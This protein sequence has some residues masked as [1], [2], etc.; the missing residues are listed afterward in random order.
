MSYFKNICLIKSPQKVDVPYSLIVSDLTEL[1]YLAAMVKNDVDSITFPVNINE[2]NYFH[3]FEKYL[4]H[5]KADMVGISTMTGAYKNALEFARIAKKHNV[6]VVMGGYHPSALPDDVLKSPY[7]DAVI[8]GEGEL[9]FKE[10]VNNG[11]SEDIRGLSFKDNGNISH[12]TDR[13][14][15]TNLDEV[16]HPMRE[17]RPK[18]FGNRGDNYSIDTVYTSR[19]CRIK[20]SFCSNDMV[21]KN[22]RYRSPENV[23]E[24]LKMI[25]STKKRKILK[26]WDANL[27]TSV[28]RIERIVDLMFENNLTNF[29][30]W[31]ESRSTDILKAEPIMQKLH[32]IGLRNM[33]LG[34]ESPNLETLK[35]VGKGTTPQTCERAIELMRN[36]RIK[37]QGYFIIGHLNETIEDIRRYPEYAKMAGVKQ[38]IFMVMTPYPG[39]RIYKDYKK[40]NAITSYNWNMY[41]NF[42]TVV[43]PNNID[44]KT[45]KKAA[46]YCWGKFY[47]VNPYSKGRTILDI[48]QNT[49]FRLIFVTIVEKNDERNSVPDLQDYMLEYLQTFVTSHL[50]DV[51]CKASCILKPLGRKIIFRFS[52]SNGTSVDF[53]FTVN[54]SS[55][56]LTVTDETNTDG[57]RCIHITL[58]DILKLEEKLSIMR[59]VAITTRH[60]IAKANKRKRILRYLALIFDRN[61]H[62]SMYQIVAFLTKIT[63]KNM[64]RK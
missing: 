3:Y 18:R 54:G 22:W 29:K 60:Q 5:H 64:F 24:E 14:V 1:C 59:L 55:G 7:V 45:L 2:V 41:N 9:T 13:D 46:V 53:R 10:L 63:G 21:N 19:G 4:K 26:L 17:I 31:T 58:E 6:Y 27:L 50:K 57:Y 44:T 11:P 25:H 61:L 35:K 20:C 62:A 52:H 47:G 42:G 37:V 23:I 40:E 32:D 15:I 49:I 43:E 51:D 56:N 30:I 48:V 36:Y 8:R 39:T 16:P 34:I 33:S 28:D 12:N 38:A